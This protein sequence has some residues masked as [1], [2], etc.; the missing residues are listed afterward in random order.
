MVDDS[1]YGLNLKKIKINSGFVP[2]DLC[3]VKE[4]SWRIGCMIIETKGFSKPSF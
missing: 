2:A 4:K 1:R 3:F